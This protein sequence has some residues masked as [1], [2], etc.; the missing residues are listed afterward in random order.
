MNEILGL[1][2]DDLRKI[3]GELGV[4]TKEMSPRN[5]SK[6]LIDLA[7]LKLAKELGAPPAVTQNQMTTR[8]FLLEK[9]HEIFPPDEMDLGTIINYLR[10]T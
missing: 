10:G 6:S 9:G 5:V 3:A 2:P 1:I 4:E 7:Y 8:R